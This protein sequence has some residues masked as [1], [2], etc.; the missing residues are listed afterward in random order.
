MLGQSC[1]QSMHSAAVRQ[2]SR[3][4]PLAGFAACGAAGQTIGRPSQRAIRNSR[5]RIVGAP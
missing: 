1:D 5:L 3:P 4:E 2:G